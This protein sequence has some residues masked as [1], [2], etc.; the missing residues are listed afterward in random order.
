MAKEISV[1]NGIIRAAGGLI[2]R[3]S[4]HGREIA[5]IYRARYGDW[6]LPKGKLNSGEDWQEAAVREVKEET[7]YSVKVEEFA[8]EVRYQI[9]GVPKVVRFWNM[10]PEGESQFQQSEEVERVVWLPVSEA[11]TRLNYDAEKEILKKNC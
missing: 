1:E 4:L 10:A 11:L 2:W 7:G 8:G 3:D 6:T 9:K 5:V